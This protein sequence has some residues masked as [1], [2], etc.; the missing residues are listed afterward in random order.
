MQRRKDWLPFRDLITIYEFTLSNRQHYQ[1]NL[2]T[3]FDSAFE[4]YPNTNQRKSRRS[5]SAESLREYSGQQQVLSWSPAY[6][7]QLNTLGA[8]AW[9]KTQLKDSSFG[10]FD[11]C[12]ELESCPLPH[13]GPNSQNNRAAKIVGGREG[14]IWQG[15]HSGLGHHST[16]PHQGTQR[17]LQLNHLKIWKRRMVR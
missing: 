7:H 6:E 15:S 9:T 14:Q 12:A 13:K 4:L 1:N 16:Q 3:I 2:Q 10:T 17:T 5:S 11:G 8:P